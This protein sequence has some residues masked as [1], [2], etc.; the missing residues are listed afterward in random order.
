M[1]EGQCVWTFPNLMEQ[2]ENGGKSPDIKVNGFDYVRLDTVKA[3]L[4]RQREEIVKRLELKKESIRNLTPDEK[5]DGQQALSDAIAA[6][7]E[8]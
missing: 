7:K 1:H 3:M 8:M 4:D 6:V 5:P 2:I